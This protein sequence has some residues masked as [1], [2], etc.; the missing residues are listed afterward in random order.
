MKI[1]ITA[2]GTGGHIFP[3]LAIIN[4]IKSH[5]KNSKFL[6]F[7]TTDRMEKDIIP[8]KGI[9]YI[10]IQMKGLNRKNIL[11]NI[12]VL[13]IYLAAI[14]KAEVELKKFK[15]DI[16]IGVGGYITAPVLVAAN[17]LGIKTIIHEQN[18][19]PGVSNKLLSHFVN[20]ICVSFKESE[21]YFPKKKTIYTGNPRSEEILSMEKGKREDF[22][23][24]HKSKFII[25]VMGSLGSLT[26]TKKMKELIPSFKDKDYQV[27]VVTGKNYYDDYK[28][29]K[30]PTNVKIVPFYDAKYMKDADLII[31]RSGAST[32]AEVTALL[33]PSIM[34]PSPYVTH[35]HQYKNAKAL[36]DKKACKILEEK[37]FCKENLL[38][39]IDECFK[40]EVYNEMRKN[41]KEFSC[42][43]S[44][45]AIY[46]EIMRLVRNEE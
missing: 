2:G 40:K 18:S 11:K 45:E 21:A 36:E 30:T 10:G 5:D 34:I 9:P 39:L 16:V 38:S 4:K 3:A 29:V 26:M 19:I 28:D 25:L 12:T 46:K 8:E 13:K 7:G 41:L 27:L 14:K 23:F 37:D 22:G 43:N 17:H 15:P 20:K 42:P 33:L 44:A 31:T 6:Y 24:N 35:N 1:A 32:I